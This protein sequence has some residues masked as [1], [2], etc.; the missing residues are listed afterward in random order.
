MSLQ[1]EQEREGMLH[2]P[3]PVSTALLGM[4]SK[5]DIKV[6]LQ[7]IDMILSKRPLTLLTIK[8]TSVQILLKNGRMNLISPYYNYGNLFYL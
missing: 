6:L 1:I 7:I 5:K 3:V 4:P 8:G 2:C